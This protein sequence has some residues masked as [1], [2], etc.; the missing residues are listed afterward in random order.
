MLLWLEENNIEFIPHKQI[1]NSSKLTDV[2]LPLNNLW[3]EIDGINR[4][5]NKKYL[6][7][8]YDRWKEKLGIYERENLDLIIVNNFD[9]FKEKLWRIAQR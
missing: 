9:Q 1:P 8:N 6:S 3:V 5:K 4:E 2:Y 7:T